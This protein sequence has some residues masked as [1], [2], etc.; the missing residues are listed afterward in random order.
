MTKRDRKMFDSIGLAVGN[1][2]LCS[3]EVLPTLLKV[4]ESY[5]HTLKILREGEH[6]RTVLVMVA[7]L[8]G[9]GI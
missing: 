2:F 5:G 3:M 4:T 8:D 6:E 1:V 7:Q 9:S